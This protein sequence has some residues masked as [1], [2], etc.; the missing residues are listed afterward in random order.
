M[1][2]FGGGN[3]RIQRMVDLKCQV[4]ELQHWEN[5]RS[6]MLQ[7]NEQQQIADSLEITSPRLIKA[8]LAHGF[9]GESARLLLLYPLI[10]VA[11]SNSPM[12]AEIAEAVRVACRKYGTLDSEESRSLLEGWLCVG[13]SLE[14]V[15]LWSQVIGERF[16]AE[17]ERTLQELESYL[18]EHAGHLTML[19]GGLGGLY[20]VVAA[21]RLVI[22]RFQQAICSTLQP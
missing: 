2:A 9:S 12:S 16:R 10:E 3:R 1:V 17:G 13:P 20:S 19:S 15:D 21:E 6:Q 7:L 4:H 11:W 22:S 5:Y 8:L 18:I 14:L